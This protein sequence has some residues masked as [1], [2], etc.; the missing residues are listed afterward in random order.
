ME[1]AASGAQPADEVARGEFFTV[2]ASESE[3]QSQCAGTF[4]RTQS[5]VIAVQRRAL[6]RDSTLCH[7]KFI[8]TR[9]HP[10]FGA[11]YLPSDPS[12]MVISGLNLAEYHLAIF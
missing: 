9:C 1:T 12:N 6:M 11:R 8:P 2:L 7:D 4:D 5:E 3:R 10:T